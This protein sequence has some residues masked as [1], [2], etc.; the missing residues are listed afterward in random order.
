MKKVV[1]I[2]LGASRRD[3]AFTA[4]F[5]GQTLRVRRL[6]ADGSLRKASHLLHLW[7][8]AATPSAWGW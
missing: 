8:G 4:H 1:G 7:D 6:G 5:L 2:S 3:H